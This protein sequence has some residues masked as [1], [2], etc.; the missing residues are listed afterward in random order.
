LGTG[1]WANGPGALSPH[2]PKLWKRGTSPQPAQPDV[3]L[4]DLSA[5]GVSAVV[6]ISRSPAYDNQPSFV[7]D[8]RAILFSSNRDGQ[9]DIYRFDI[10][11]GRLTR[12][13]STPT[14]EYSPTPTPD[15]RGFSVIQVEADNAQRLWRFDLDGANPRVILADVKP[16]GYHA[17]IDAT[18]LALFVL[19]SPATLQLAD[20]TTGRADVVATGIG[21]SVLFRQASREVTF[22]SQPAGGR[23]LLRSVNPDTRAVADLVEPLEESQ[24]LAWLASGTALMARGSTIYRWQ[25]G[26]RA[27]WTPFADLSSFPLANITRMAAAPD[28]RRLALVAEP[29]PE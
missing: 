10:A 23:R 16:V 11:D 4:A 7:P 2:T 14:S 3:F 26:G 24:D 6:N 5:S 15:G 25:P 12:L 29:R 27:A 1:L 19:G 9:N 13:T 18:R 20:T 22:I 17:W 28:G 21:R 8:S